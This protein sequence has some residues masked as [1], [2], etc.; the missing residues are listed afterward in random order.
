[1]LCTF[2]CMYTLYRLKP[3]DIFGNYCHFL[4]L[5]YLSIPNSVATSLQVREWLALQMFSLL[6]GGIFCLMTDLLFSHGTRN[7]DAKPERN[8]V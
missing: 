1:M 2:V 7:F 5:S 6:I 8:T 3:G 4:S